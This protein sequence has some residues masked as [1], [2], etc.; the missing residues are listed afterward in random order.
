MGVAEFFPD[1]NEVWIHSHIVTYGHAAD[2]LITERIRHEIE[3]MWNEPALSMKADTQQRKFQFRITAHYRSDLTPLEVI[4]NTDPLINFFRIEDKAP[5]NISF[6]DG[7]GC[8]TGY[9][10]LDNLYEG[11][12]T[13]A[14]EYGHTL[15]LR[16]P[17]D[18][19]LRGKGRPGIMYPRGTIVDSEFQYNPGAA[20]GDNTQGGTMHPCHRRVKPEDLSQIRIGESDM[21]KGKWL[22]GDFS[23]VWHE[24]Y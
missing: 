15:G 16:H 5:G 13:A 11:S 21:E 18:L 6:V 14:H 7:I 8:N 20:A 23:S 24:G 12:T 3:W 9:F 19:D 2:P 1:L 4:S 17:L 22:I 10:L